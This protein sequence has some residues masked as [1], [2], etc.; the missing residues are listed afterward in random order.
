MPTAD[1][2]APKR[3]YGLPSA[4]AFVAIAAVL[5]LVCAKFLEGG[6]RAEN[7]RDFP[8][9]PDFE[10]LAHDGTKLS[11]ADLRGDV[12]VANFIFTRC[13]G[14]CPLITGQ[15]A[16]VQQELKKGKVEGVKLVSI[17][18]DPDYDSRDVLKNYAEQVGADPA[19]WKFVTGPKAQVEA[20]I[21][22]GFLQALYAGADGE[23]IH[24][25]RFVVV[26][27]EGRMRAFPDGAEPGAAQKILMEIGRIL[28]EKPSG[29]N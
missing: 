12:W 29:S 23:P 10:F 7:A 8:K 15:M 22:K 27:R 21:R 11:A 13:T 9:A 6:K 2:P 5:A 28:R 17:T 1:A 4:I 19:M 24:S 16:E 14:P 20:A 3:S 26:D 18:V 25:Q